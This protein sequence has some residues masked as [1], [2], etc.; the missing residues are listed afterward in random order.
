L[1]SERAF[2]AVTADAVFKDVEDME[3]VLGNPR[4]TQP[5]MT[6]PVPR[7]RHWEGHFGRRSTNDSLAL[8]VM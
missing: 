8:F 5:L 3:A 2:E 7:L 6:L 4:I 1:T